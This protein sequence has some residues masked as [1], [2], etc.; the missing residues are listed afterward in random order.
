MAEGSTTSLGERPAWVSLV[1]PSVSDIV[2]IGMLA[3]LV[4]T[5]LSVRLLGDAGIGWHIRT[6]QLIVATH[7]IPRA[8]VFS[9]TMQGKAWFAW[10]WF[11]DLVAGWLEHAAGL[12]GV[13]WFTAAVIAA[14]FAWA[15][16]LLVRRGAD[17]L[18]ALTLVLLAASASMIHFFARPHVV[19]WLF[20][21]VWF[22][23]LASFERRGGRLVW[24]LPPLMIVWVNVH[25][26]FLVGFV[27][28]AIYWISAAWLWRTVRENRLDDFLTKLRAGKRASTLG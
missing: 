20:V 4:C 24:M 3:V 6:G 12:N 16:R 22:W 21:L 19:S 18:V 5:S 10:E 13:V 2:F 25:G 14:V 8:D 26:G 15:F 9:A 17:V 1:L 7:G 23:V 11:Y 28:L 27:L